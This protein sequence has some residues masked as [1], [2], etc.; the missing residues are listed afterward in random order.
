MAVRGRNNA[1][2]ALAVALASGLTVQEAARKAGVSERTTF[3]RLADL[4]FRQRVACARAEMVTQ[5]LGM[6]AEGMTAAAG[7]L[8]QLLTASAD[9]VKLGAARSIL[10]L[11]VRLRESV[12]LEQRLTILE[13]QSEVVQ[14]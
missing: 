6:M 14:R 8:R 7:T 1:D 12:E 13:Q 10:E 2:D 9:T 3:R 5:A 4:G 11:T